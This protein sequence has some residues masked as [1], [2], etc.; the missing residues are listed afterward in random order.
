MR[1]PG[2]VNLISEHTDYNG[3]S[4]CP[5]ALE[6]DFVFAIGKTVAE[7]GL[8]HISHLE[9]NNAV[10]DQEHFNPDS[11]NPD[12]SYRDVAKPT[13][14]WTMYVRAGFAAA[15]MYDPSVQSKLHN[16]TL[17]GDGTVPLGSGLSSSSALNCASAVAFLVFAGVKE[18]DF[19][20]LAGLCAKSEA[21][22]SI[23]GGGMDQAVSLNAEKNK[24]CIVDFNPVR[25]HQV[26]FLENIKIAVFSSLKDSKKATGSCNF[27][28]TRVAECRIGCALLY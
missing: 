28:N 22:V 27:Y 16:M 3:Y 18:I 23:E 15:V 14:Q 19:P 26:P 5:L 4:V 25:V 9:N 11:F 8:V 12:N 1:S 7:D 2:R 17:V 24:I 10:E 6:K 21:M 20:L 13:K